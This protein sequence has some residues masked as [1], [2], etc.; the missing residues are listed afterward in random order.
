MSDEKKIRKEKVQSDNKNM[1]ENNAQNAH[2][3]T[4]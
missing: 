3:F 2:I 1:K 4:K